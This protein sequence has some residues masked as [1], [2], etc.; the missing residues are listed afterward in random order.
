MQGNSVV[1]FHTSPVHS[2]GAARWEGWSVL[3]ADEGY[4]VFFIDAEGNKHR[5]KLSEAAGLPFHEYQPVRKPAAYKKQRHLSGYYFFSTTGRHV[6]Y[7]SRLEMFVL[8]TLDFE[9]HVVGVSA[10]PFKLWYRRDRKDRSHVPDF[11]AKLSDGQEL[12]VDVKQ[13][14]VAKRPRN[15]QVFKI[16]AHACSQ[17]GWQYKVDSGPKEPYLSNIK[18]LA[19]F[20]RMPANKD[21]EHYAEAI[22]DLCTERPRSI[23]YLTESI[24]PSASVRPVLFHLMWKQIVTTP[25]DTRLTNESLILLPDKERTVQNA[26]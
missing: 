14:A 16:T 12:V 26:E 20:R 5:S 17:A 3:E 11:F 10:Q 13:E 19:G 9:P 1:E 21:F 15:Q 25:L 22:V 6:L 2:H 24:G 23:S 8:M 7:E 4:E 18:W